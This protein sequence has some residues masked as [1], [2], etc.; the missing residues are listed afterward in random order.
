MWT[1]ACR[2]LCGTARRSP[3]SVDTAG[4]GE[5][6]LIGW[7]GDLAV[8]APWR[9]RGLGQALLLHSFGLFAEAGKRRA[10]LG[11]D[12]DNATGALA[13]YERVG[14]RVVRQ[15]NTWEREQ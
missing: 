1:P 8:R 14:L 3:D 12:R 13:L 9:R 2:R 7:I 10:G 4:H 11:V 15:S 5:D 6:E